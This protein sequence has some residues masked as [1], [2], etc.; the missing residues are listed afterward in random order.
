[1]SI[2]FA[3]L[4]ANDPTFLDSINQISADWNNQD[5]I[6]SGRSS[7]V[8]VHPVIKEIDWR[9]YDTCYGNFYDDDD[10]KP[11][12]KQ[13]QQQQHHQQQQPQHRP[14]TPEPIFAN[15]SYQRYTPS[16][17]VGI[18]TLIAR[19]LPRDITSE[20]LHIVFAPYGS[21]KDIY[22]PKNM[23]KSSPYFGTT[24]G[25]AL[26]KFVSSDDT[27]KA[28]ND[29]YGRIF[30]SGNKITLEFAKEDR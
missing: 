11:V 30:I 22:I 26:I 12:K 17:S 20:M 21:I 8:F 2:N 3:E 6:K 25:F 23:D 24:K 28:F 4:M 14:V 13:Y 19:N 10:V 15:P 29:E 5:T 1:M 27:A 9:I 7:P 16:V 18:K